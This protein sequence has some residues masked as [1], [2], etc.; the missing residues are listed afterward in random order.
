MCFVQQHSS[1]CLQIA[2]ALCITNLIDKNEDGEHFSILRHVLR[3]IVDIYIK[4]L[5]GYARFW[6][7][8]II[9]LLGDV[10]F[11]LFLYPGLELSH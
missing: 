3:W 2:A 9:A 4:P 10:A 5:I 7:I 6:Y 8:A 1:V 11:D